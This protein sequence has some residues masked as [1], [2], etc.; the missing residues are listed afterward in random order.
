MARPPSEDPLEAI[1]YLTSVGV[2]PSSTRRCATAAGAGE[3]VG[4]DAAQVPR[5]G[6]FLLIY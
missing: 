1:M 6:I 5:L 4:G 3:E 2:R